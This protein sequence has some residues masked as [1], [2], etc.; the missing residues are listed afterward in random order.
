MT[1]KMKAIM[2]AAVVGLAEDGIW[3]FDETRRWAV[4]L[5]RFMFE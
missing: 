3:Q 5:H 2:D 4:T 1:V